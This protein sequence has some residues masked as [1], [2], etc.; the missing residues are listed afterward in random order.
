MSQESPSATSSRRTSLASRLKDTAESLRS[1]SKSR[2]RPGSGGGDRSP[3]K[4]PDSA[5]SR[6][7]SGAGGVFSSTLSLFRKRERKK[8]GD[9]TPDTLDG[10]HQNLDGI[11]KVEFTFNQQHTTVSSLFF[12]RSDR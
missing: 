7:G 8:S 12:L 1:R 4:R 9:G 11:G 10:S 5:R 6:G 3:H 2:E